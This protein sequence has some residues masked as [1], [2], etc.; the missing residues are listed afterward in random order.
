MMRGVVGRT[1][2]GELERVVMDQLW[3][4]EGAATV[5]DVYVNGQPADPATWLRR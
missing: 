2:L 4:F 3:A 1:R 5:T